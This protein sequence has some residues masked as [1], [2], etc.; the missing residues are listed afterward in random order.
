MNP[1]RP[2]EVRRLLAE[3]DVRPSRAMGQ[4]FLVDGNIRDI[5][6]SAAEL[7]GNDRVLE[8]GPGLGALTTALA[9]AA[10]AVVAVEKDHR[11]AAYLQRD[12][13]PLFANLRILRADVLE[14]DL[15][16][17]DPVGPI[18]KVV[19]NLPYSAGSRVLVDLAGLDAPPERVVVTVQDEVADRILAPAGSAAFGL[20]SLWLQ[21]VYDARHVKS[22]RAGCFWPRPQVQSSVVLLTRNAHRWQSRAEQ[23]C[24]RSL[25][26]RAFEHRRKQLR[27]VLGR[28]PLVV[29][30]TPEGIERS[31]GA[32][33]LRP[34]SRAE[35]LSP[36][37]WIRLV[38]DLRG[39]ES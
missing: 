12:V 18:G 32:L 29:S 8:V 16:A 17:P 30:A 21:A 5:I 33:G 13:A 4:N 23:E 25:T 35:S 28:A 39:D 31:L 7:D 22:V 24:F 19:S 37:L 11:L 3:L 27:G 6:V 38:R 34:D 14:L 1:T 20:L 2:T 26:R 15:G 10:G 9:S 36:P